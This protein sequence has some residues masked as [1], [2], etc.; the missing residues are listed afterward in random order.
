MYK[1][2]NRLVLIVSLL[3][4]AGF[5]ITS[6]ASYLVSLS[7]LSQQLSQSELPITSDNIYSE[8]QRDLIRPIFISSLMANDTFLRDWVLSGEND[9]TLVIKYLKEIKKKFNAVTSFFVSDRTH[10]YYYSDGILKTVNPD[11]SRD[12]WYF[13]VRDM[14]PDY[15][16]NI[17]PDMANR[18]AMTIFINYRVYDYDGNFIG[19]TGVGLTVSAV[20]EL[21]EQFKNKYG[22]FVYFVNPKGVVELYGSDF[23][24]SS[25][26]IHE[27]EGIRDYADVIL[28][29]KSSSFKYR[30]NGTTHYV[31]TRYI[32]E[33]GWYLIVEQPA[34]RLTRAIYNTLL[35]NLLICTVITFVVVLVTNVTISSYQKR[36]EE[37]ASIDKLTGIYNRQAFDILLEETLKDARRRNTG[38]SMIM[39]DLDHFK[40]VNDTAGHLAGDAVLRRITEISRLNIRASDVICR[41]GGEEFIILLKECSREDLTKLAEKIRIAIKDSLVEFDGNIVQTSASFGITEYRAPETREQFLIRTD[42]ALYM[43]KDQ[44]RNRTVYL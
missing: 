37:L 29:Q 41:W 34:N 19:A 35:V 11:E 9:E 14:K 44:G 23:S 15:E 3:L 24:D 42:E 10:R 27:M 40:K 28:S 2:K 4:V 1:Q 16:I 26:D 30:K 22:R 39:Y 13:R 33:F 7:S 38:V 31:N 5:L 32:E 43:A 25:S 8:I 12:Q 21:I 6:L 36:L 18:D 20:K 17:D